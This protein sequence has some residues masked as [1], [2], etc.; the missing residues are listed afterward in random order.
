MPPHPL[1]DFEIQKSYQNEPRFND[2]Y[3]RDNLQKLKDGAYI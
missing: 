1:A 2:V 3:A